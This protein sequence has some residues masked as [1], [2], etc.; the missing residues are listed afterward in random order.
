MVRVVTLEA[1]LIENEDALR[2][3]CNEQYRVVDFANPKLS[4]TYISIQL[5]CI[6]LCMYPKA[7]H[8]AKRS[9]NNRH[10]KSVAVAPAVDCCPRLDIDLL[11]QTL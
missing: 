6:W 4:E 10:G 1:V 8:E 7:A 2:I 9:V 3:G 11:F 5:A